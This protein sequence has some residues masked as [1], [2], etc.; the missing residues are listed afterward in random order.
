MAGWMHFQS[1]HVGFTRVAQVTRAILVFNLTLLAPLSKVDETLGF[2]I[3]RH[4]GGA[5]KS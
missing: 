2:G 1:I 4:F 5:L 3:R